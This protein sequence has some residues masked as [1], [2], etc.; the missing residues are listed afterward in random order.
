MGKQPHCRRQ[1]HRQ[2][3][4]FPRLHDERGQRPYR[5]SPDRGR[6]ARPDHPQYL[7]HAGAC[8][9]R[10]RD[11]EQSQ[12]LR[13]LDHRGQPVHRGRVHSL[14]PGLQRSAAAR[15]RRRTSQDSAAGGHAVTNIRFLDNRFST[16]QYPHGAANHSR[17]VGVWGTWFFRG[18]WPP[19]FGGPT[20]LWNVGGSL[21]SGNV[22]LETG[23]N[24]DR[25]GPDGCEGANTSPA[26]PAGPITPPTA[27]P[28]ASR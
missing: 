26:A 19:Y 16:S 1:S 10:R 11:L 22:V 7:R 23:Q 17:C 6:L 25:G 28:P 18:R 3:Q 8:D 24:I 4:L 5:R 12:E 21:R 15:P 27:A 9:K 2:G 13:R 20:D 14:C